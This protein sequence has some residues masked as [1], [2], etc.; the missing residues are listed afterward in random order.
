MRAARMSIRPEALPGVKAA[1]LAL[2]D[3]R[4]RR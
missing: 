1:R 4:R 3:M 2:R